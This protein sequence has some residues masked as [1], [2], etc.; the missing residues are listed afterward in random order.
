MKAAVIVCLVFLPLGCA[1]P[2]K[3]TAPAGPGVSALVL[4]VPGRAM[5]A[6]S[7]D[8]TGGNFDTR[9]VEPGQTITILEH[10]GGPGIIE[11]F[12]CT[13]APRAN[14][15][16]HRQAILRLY[17][18]CSDAPAVECPV[19]DFFGVGFG[20]QKDFIS[21]PL[22]QASGGYNC[23]WPMPFKRSARWT[24]TNLSNRR[25]DAFYFNIDYRLLPAGSL[26]QDVRYFHAQWR[27][28]NPTDPGKNYVILD[29]DGTGHYVGC[30]MSMQAIAPMGLSFLEGDEQVFIDGETTPSIVGTGTEDYFCSGWYYDRGEYSAPYHGVIIKDEQLSRICT[31]RWHIP[32]PKPFTRSVRVEIEHGH[33]N[34]NSADYSSTAFFY[35]T[36]VNTPPPPLPPAERLLASQPPQPRRFPGVLEAEE[37]PNVTVTAGPIERQAMHAFAGEWSAGGQLGWRPDA[38]GETMAFDVA[39]PRSG[40]FQIVAF[41]TRAPDYG[42]VRF[43]IAGEPLPQEVDL[44]APRVEPT[45]RLVLGRVRLRVGLNRM[46]VQVTGRSQR[47]TGQMVGIDAIGLEP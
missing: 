25:I 26:P 38:A 34:E 37:L 20:V 17:W 41:L 28:Q 30:A 42:R 22:N 33:A 27:R 15:E 7:W 5:Q 39:A 2:E 47:S 29:T 18:D 46:S 19:G 45:G 12:W 31:Y 14:P 21:A 6:S 11:R 24:L 40:E 10:D 43:T 35:A 16:I 36:G 3:P 23:Y 32:D 4:P 44:Y 8:R 1:T 13:I 9:A